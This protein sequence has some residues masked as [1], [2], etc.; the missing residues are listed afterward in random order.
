MLW[1]D[2]H[3]LDGAFDD[4]LNRNSNVGRITGS[5]LVR[6]VLTA[7][8]HVGGLVPDMTALETQKQAIVLSGPQEEIKPGLNGEVFCRRRSVH[9]LLRV[10][11]KRYTAS[12]RIRFAWRYSETSGTFIN[13]SSGQLQEV[14]QAADGSALIDEMPL[15]TFLRGWMDGLVS[16]RTAD[17]D[18]PRE[19][20]AGPMLRGSQQRLRAEMNAR[21]RCR[22]TGYRNAPVPLCRAGRRM[23]QCGPMRGPDCHS[24]SLTPPNLAIFPADPASRCNQQKSSALSYKGTQWRYCA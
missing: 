12:L 9:R 21:R 22:R 14:V 4:T 5:N 8:E 23:V 16:C 19:R 20:A 6:I 7:S 10:S 15:P 2:A 11:P 13:C 17:A 3:G 24:G 1:Q 18:C